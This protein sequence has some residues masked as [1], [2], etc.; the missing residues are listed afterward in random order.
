M[1]RAVDAGYR[2]VAITG[3]HL[4]SYGRDVAETEWLQLAVQPQ[5]ARR[6]VA[7]GPQCSVRV[8]QPVGD[9]VSEATAKEALRLAAQKLSVTTRFIVRRDYSAN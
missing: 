8:H 9:R 5:D 2:E 3:V 6:F 1:R 4:G 7:S